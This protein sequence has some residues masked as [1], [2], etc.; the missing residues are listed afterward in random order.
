[1][2]VHRVVVL[3]VGEVV[4]YDMQIPPQIFACAE[5]GGRPLYDVRV[6]GVDDRPVRVSSGYSALLDHGPE[7]LDDA[8]TVIV[9]GTRL[10]GPRRDGSLPDDVTTALA[11]IPASARVMSICTGAFVLAAAGLLNGRPATTH[12][13]HADRL[14]TLYP[15]VC[16]DENVLFVDDGDVLTSA[17]LAAG[18]D[19]CLHVVRSDHGSDV[20]NRAARYCVVPPWRDGGQ[21]QYI[22]RPFTDAVTGSTAPTRAWALE[23]LGE[24]LDLAALAAHARMSMRTFN[25][26]FRDETGLPPHTWLTRQRVLHARHLLEV[27][28]LP[29]DRV[30]AE[31]GLGTAASLRKH[32]RTAIGVSPLA[33]RRTFA[34]QADAAGTHPD[35]PAHT[36]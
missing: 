18:V 15:E 30:A 10:P 6:C 13:A 26:R 17:G 1:M 34:A 9:P 7:A 11:R 4:G 29:V 33:Y 16:L 36:R 5:Q 19:L 14:R 8:D 27:T 20:A 12:W 32:L 35:E 2:G 3:A 23:R 21:S 25:R 28:D 22:D 24:P 31:S